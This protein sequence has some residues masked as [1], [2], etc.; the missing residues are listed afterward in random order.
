MGFELLCVLLGSLVGYCVGRII[1]MFISTTGILTI[2]MTDPEVDF[3]SMHLDNVD[4]VFTKKYVLLKIVKH[5]DN[6]RKKQ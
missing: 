1:H 2:N 3:M 4:Q 6:E 5:T